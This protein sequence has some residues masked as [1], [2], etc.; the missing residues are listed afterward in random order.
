MKFVCLMLN[1]DRIDF[2]LLI[3]FFSVMNSLADLW[4]SDADLEV[5][6]AG[7]GDNES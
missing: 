6:I 2:K 7:G 1:I 3:F 4:S 5:Q